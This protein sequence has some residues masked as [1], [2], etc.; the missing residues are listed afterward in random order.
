MVFH[1]NLSD[2]KSTQVSRTLL[3]ILADFNNAVIWKVSACLPISALS[4]LT[5]PLGIVQSA[6]VTISIS[7]TFMFDSIFSSQA[8]S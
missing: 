1:W 7:A 8:K 3:K 6:Q 2:S 4:P 5:K